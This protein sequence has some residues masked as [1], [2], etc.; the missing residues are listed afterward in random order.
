GIIDRLEL[1]DGGLVVTDYKTGRPPSSNW[2]LRSLAGGPFYAFLC[3]QVLGPLPVAVR[4]LYL[5]SGEI[6]EAV[7][8]EQSARF[9]VSRTAAGWRA[10]EQACTSCTMSPPPG[11]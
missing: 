8:S 10:V 7:P 4:L 1:R 3:Q 6:I 9:V 5:S 2:E 11:R